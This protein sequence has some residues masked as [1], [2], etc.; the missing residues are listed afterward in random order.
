MAARKL[1]APTAF[2]V[3]FDQVKEKLPPAV[4]IGLGNFGRGQ[5]IANGRGRCP[6]PGGIETIATI[7]KIA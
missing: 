5:K 7:L 4:L 1:R 6:L 2:Q 3:D